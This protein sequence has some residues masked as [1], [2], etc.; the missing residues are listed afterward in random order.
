[1]PPGKRIPVE[2]NDMR[3]PKGDHASKLANLCRSIVRNPNY[4]PLQVEKW[5][6]IPNQAKEMMWKYIKE[7]T[8]VAEEWRKWIMQSMAKKFRGHIK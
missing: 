8:D 7:H 5:N 4:A 2:F 6:D 3:Q 1:M